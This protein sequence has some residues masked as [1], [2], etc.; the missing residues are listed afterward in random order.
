MTQRAAVA[1]RDRLVSG[2][3]SRRRVV[4]AG[5]LLGAGLVTGACGGGADPEQDPGRDDGRTGPPVASV[6]VVGA[7][8][9]G[10]TAAHQLLAA[11]VE[12][13]VLEAAPSHGGR[14][15]RTLGF[16]D[17]PIALGAE[18][19]HAGPDT[20]VPILGDDAAAVELVA[21][22]PDATLGVVD[23]G[24]TIG[25][26]TGDDDLMFAAS[27]W[28]DVFEEHLVPGVADRLRTG[29]RVVRIEDTGDGVEV[30]DEQGGAVRADAV[31]VTVP[32]AVLRA[33]T[34]TFVPDLPAATWRAIDGVEL[35]GGLKA[36]LEFDEPFYPTFLVFPDS[37][38][39]AGQRLYFD[40][41]Y[42][43]D[44]E[45]HLLGLFAVGAPAEPYRARVGDGFVEYVLA[46]LD[47]VLGGSATRH[48]RR[49]VV[50]DWSAEPDI[51]QAY[52]ADGADARM[53]RRLGEPVS[54]RVLFAGDAYTDGTDWSA[55]HLA[56]ASARTAVA[57]LLGRR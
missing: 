29:T 19:L 50:Q 38:T 31:V 44:T 54:D 7:G 20:L 51:R 52:V 35:W 30:V 18:W 24:L 3:I 9:A 12:V 55:V 37:D 48:Y 15:R 27:S 41:T 13:T 23:D 28:F 56:A 34:I 17:V 25:P 8:A 26:L 6:V 53:V 40:T 39:A 49:H 43:R 42:G 32:V 14:M 57:R 2:G 46:E 1:G 33:R 5:A 22:G 21:Y 10:L 36:F 47:A 16:A 4:H 45:A 11:G